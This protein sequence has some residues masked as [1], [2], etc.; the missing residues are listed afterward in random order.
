MKENPRPA[1]TLLKS[2]MGEIP[3]KVKA[4]RMGDKDAPIVAV[5]D[6]FKRGNGKMWK[7]LR[8]EYSNIETEPVQEMLKNLFN[9]IDEGA[10]EK[11]GR[12]FGDELFRE[13]E[14]QEWW[15]DF[16]TKYIY[17]DMFTESDEVD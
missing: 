6:V 11:H 9:E 5:W 4:S 1:R 12:V 16:H 15:E 8:K 3:I 14:D 2:I 7:D 10:S 13:S 17:T